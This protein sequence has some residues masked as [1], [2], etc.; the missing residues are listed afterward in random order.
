MECHETEFP[1]IAA[2]FKNSNFEVNENNHAFSSLP[3]DQAN[4]QNNTIVKRDGG[5]IGLREG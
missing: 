4:E 1:A 3:V 5:A 2:K